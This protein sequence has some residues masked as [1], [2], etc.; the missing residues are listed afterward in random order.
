MKKIT[1]TYWFRI[2]VWQMTCTAS[3]KKLHYSPLFPSH[4]LYRKFNLG[5]RVAVW[6]Y[7]S[8]ATFLDKTAQR[9]ESFRQIKPLASLRSLTSKQVFSCWQL[10]GTTVMFLWGWPLLNLWK[11]S[12][13]PRTASFPP[14]LPMLMLQ[15]MSELQPTQHEIQNSYITTVSSPGWGHNQTHSPVHCWHLQEGVE[16][17]V[18]HWKMLVMSEEKS[19][20]TKLWEGNPTVSCYYITFIIV[21]GK[22]DDQDKQWVVNSTIG[23][24]EEHSESRNKRMEGG[25]KGGKDVIRLQFILLTTQFEVFCLVCHCQLGG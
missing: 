25:I 4:I 15:G 21:T 8:R 7:F 23:V 24:F 5:R 2:A 14:Q 17:L 20:W 12:T 6:K 18:V 13:L 16:S 9:M 3:L 1:I 11:L 19:S 22:E 10:M